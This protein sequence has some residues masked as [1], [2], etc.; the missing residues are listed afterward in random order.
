[1][2]P[3]LGSKDKD[4]PTD[5]P[6]P[7]AAPKPE[8][9]KPETAKPEG[10]KRGRK[11]GPPKEY[12]FN[13]LSAAL[14]SAPQPV[15]TQMA[16]QFAPSRARDENQIAMDGVIKKY[17]DAWLAA[18]SPTKWVDMPKCRYHIPPNAVDGFKF[19][20]RRAAD[21]HG[22]AIKWGGQQGTAVRDQSGNN[23]IVFAVR[24]RRTKD[25][26][27]DATDDEP[28]EDAHEDASTETPTE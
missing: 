14:L 12:D 1:M 5:A 17:H 20:V 19:L 13:G 6:A 8:T 23:V 7:S 24:D 18:G 4:K 11:A 26:P 2:S 3:M 22:V 25:E 28:S 16:S 10:A 15:T 9:A 21:F 27:V